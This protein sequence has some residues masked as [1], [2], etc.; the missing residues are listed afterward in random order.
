[1]HIP[2]EH[3]EAFNNWH[4][5]HVWKRL[6]G[7]L[8]NVQLAHDKDLFNSIAVQSTLQTG[9]TRKAYYFKPDTAINQHL[10][11]TILLTNDEQ[12]PTLMVE[13]PD[14][15]REYETFQI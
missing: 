13:W 9:L 4:Y 11:T 15:Q 14:G 1:M 7:A 3:F 8:E 6:L 12:L 2:I 10:F 5:S